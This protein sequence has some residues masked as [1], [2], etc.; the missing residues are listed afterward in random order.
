MNG[1]AVSLEWAVVRVGS[2]MTAM[3]ALCRAVIN[4]NGGLGREFR[5]ERASG[6]FGGVAGGGG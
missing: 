1:S 5:A 6:A 3:A 4:W 2:A